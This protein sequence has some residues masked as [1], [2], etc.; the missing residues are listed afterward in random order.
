MA[1]T[2]TPGVL[3]SVEFPDALLA[4]YIDCLEGNIKKGIIQAIEIVYMKV[5][6]EDLDAGVHSLS[7][8]AGLA[9]ASSDQ[10]SNLL[11]L[12]FGVRYI[13]LLE[14]DGHEGS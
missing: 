4:P 9:R 2:H 6:D 3:L 1:F 12:S 5:Y 14:S 13:S 10:S 8:E 11:S 7:P